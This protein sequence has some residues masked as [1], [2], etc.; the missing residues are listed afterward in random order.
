VAV[1][2]AAAKAGTRLSTRMT[3]EKTIPTARRNSLVAIQPPFIDQQDAM[4]A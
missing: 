2:K 1:K 3:G 4:A